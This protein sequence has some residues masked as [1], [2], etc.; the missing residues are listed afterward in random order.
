[1]PALQTEAA[2][3]TAEKEMKFDDINLNDDKPAPQLDLSFGLDAAADNKK[4]GSG[5]FSFGSGWGGG[6]G[7]TSW[8]FG[9]IDEKKEESKPADTGGW[10]FTSKKD[11]KKSSSGFDFDFDNFAGADEPSLDLGASAKQ[12]KAVEED[13]W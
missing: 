3:D 13:P 2:A 11:K 6:W 4:S 5:G 8:G 10:G 7:S 9:G 1:M 12:D